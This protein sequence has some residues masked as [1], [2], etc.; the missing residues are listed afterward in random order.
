MDLTKR[1]GNLKHQGA[2][3]KKHRWFNEIDFKAI[4]NCFATAPYIPTVKASD[5]S[6]NF[7]K[8]DSHQLIIPAED[9]YAKQFKNF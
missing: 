5:D 1:L 9:L 8:Y 3:V 6:S 7:P 2:D 4:M